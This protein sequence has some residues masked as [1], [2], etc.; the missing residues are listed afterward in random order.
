MYIGERDFMYMCGSDPHF[1]IWLSEGELLC[2]TFQGRYST[3]FNL[4][5]NNHLQMNALFVPDA[6]NYD[7]T[8][9]GSIRVVALRDGEKTITFQFS[10]D[11]QPVKIGEGVQLDAKTIKKIAILQQEKAIHSQRSIQL[12]PE[13]S[14]CSGGVH[15]FQALFHHWIYQEQL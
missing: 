12:H 14:L 15:R 9:L 13:I 10:T 7:N 1:A 11:D 6:T 5:G 3:I 2:Y 4:L 8:W